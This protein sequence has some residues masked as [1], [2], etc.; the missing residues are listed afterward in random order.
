MRITD[1]SGVTRMGPAELVLAV[2][3]QEVNLL[4]LTSRLIFGSG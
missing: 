3:V 4:N 1:R 2:N